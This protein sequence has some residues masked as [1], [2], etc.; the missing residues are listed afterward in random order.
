MSPTSILNGFASSAILRLLGIYDLRKQLSQSPHGANRPPGGL[1]ILA[2]HLRGAKQGPK[3]L[4][5]DNRTSY[6]Y[7][8]GVPMIK[9]IE[10]HANTTRE[11]LI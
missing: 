2:A 7:V 3:R 8:N 1:A 11:K 9:R 5:T 10:M 6:A 4:N